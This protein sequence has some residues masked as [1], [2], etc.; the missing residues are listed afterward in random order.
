MDR[1]VL[2]MKRFAW[3]LVLFARKWYNANNE[4]RS[5]MNN[6]QNKPIEAEELTEKELR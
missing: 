1:K 4:R 5:D 2:A 6:E 3:C